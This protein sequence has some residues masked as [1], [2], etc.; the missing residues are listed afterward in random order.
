MKTL[1]FAVFIVSV[2]F[3]G[4][5]PKT[6]P[7][8][9]GT[10]YEFTLIDSVKQTK[11]EIYVKAY[12][13]IAKTFTSAKDVIQMSDKEAGKIVAKAV[14]PVPGQHDSYGGTLGNDYVH[15]T[16]TIDIKDGKYRCVLSNFYHKG[17]N[18]ISHNTICS[19]GDLDNDKC[20]CGVS[21]MS[22]NRWNKIR[23]IAKEDAE[24]NL[25]DLKNYIA[26]KSND[27]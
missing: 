11:N 5:A 22:V 26:T 6:L 17:G 12:E 18:Y 4:C 2:L 20:P 21:Y 8:S 14:I 7:K 1:L 24:N 27:F 16:I 13:W 25:A 23:D 9:I 19:G 3:I 15:Y 10:T